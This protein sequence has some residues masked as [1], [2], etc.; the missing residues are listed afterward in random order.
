MP[1]FDGLNNYANIKKTTLELQEKYVERDKAVAEWMTRVGT[2]K[3]NYIYTQNEIEATK[4]ILSE[5]KG[6]EKDTEKLMA[7]KL[8]YSQELDNIKIEHLRAQIEHE[9]NVIIHNSIG[10][11]LEILTEQYGE[12]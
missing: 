4:N 12:K 10:K 3:N 8:I 5:L 1:V 9:K 2:L 6:K 11:G 7:K